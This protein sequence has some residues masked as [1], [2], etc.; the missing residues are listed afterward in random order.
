V[1]LLLDA[2]TLIWGV[3]DPSRLG[4]QAVT[5]LQDPANDL[6]QSAGTIW[7]VA[8]KVG[9]GKLTLSPPFRQWVNQAMNDL[10]A[11]VLPITVEYTDLQANLPMHHGD[12]FDRLLV[13]QARVDNVSL[14]SADSV[15]DQYGINRLWQTT[16]MSLGVVTKRLVDLIAKQCVRQT[17]LPG[18]RFRYFS[19]WKLATSQG[20]PARSHF[21]IL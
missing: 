17:E 16:G 14:V 12:P 15:F 11:T 6:L 18:R 7:E 13:A 21:M 3:D 2:H 4:P 1:K 10:G 9:L 5:A 20:A 19:G 8:I